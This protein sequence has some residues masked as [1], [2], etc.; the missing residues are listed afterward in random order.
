M[1]VV[2][3]TSLDESEYSRRT[4][5]AKF[6]N[7]PVAKLL[8]GDYQLIGYIDFRQNIRKCYRDFECSDVKSIIPTNAALTTEAAA[9]GGDLISLLDENI[10][11]EKVSK[12]YCVNHI[13]YSYIVEG[14]THYGSRCMGYEHVDGFLEVRRRRALIWR[15]APNRASAESNH[16]AIKKTMDILAQ[17]YDKPSVSKMDKKNYYA[18]RRIKVMPYSLADRS[19]KKMIRR[20]ENG[21]MPSGNKNVIETVSNISRFMQTSRAEAWRDKHG[22]NLLMTALLAN[23]HAAAETLVNAGLYSGYDSQGNSTLQ[24]A[25]LLGKLELIANIVARQGPWSL[26]ESNGVTLPVLALRNQD[27][28]VLDWLLKQGLSRSETGFI[29][30]NLLMYAAILGRV[31]AVQLL[32]EIYHVDLNQKNSEKSTALMFAAEAG[33]LSVVKYLADKQSNVHAK[34]VAGYNAAHLAAMNG[35]LESLKYLIARNINA[36]LT[37]KDGYSPL[38]LAIANKQWRC[39]R[40]LL[41]HLN[42][43]ETKEIKINDIVSE[44]IREDRIT[45]LDKLMNRYA[46]NI[47]TANLRN[48]LFF[49]ASINKSGFIRYLYDRKINLNVK[50][51]NQMTPL[52]KA[53]QLG[54]MNAVSTLLKL[55]AD[56]DEVSKAGLTALMYATLG[57][58][59]DIVRMMRGAG[60][61]N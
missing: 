33:K 50:D 19:A 48:M 28:G 15:F 49:S 30:I 44:L 59:I 36:H 47:S 18:E 4:Q 54:N 7:E 11:L 23:K 9:R 42:K 46:D 6:F 25:V 41:T 38:Y 52:M 21:W 35:N 40:F 39:V 55:N 12:S 43:L 61:K 5:A 22:R 34:N 13:T 20:L 60:I 37:N 58:H 10:N 17:V 8:N 2:D 1:V 31:D 24:Y 16:I 14:K 53:A 51:S 29:N 57:G 32:H 26:K 3:F 45:L 56:P 27:L